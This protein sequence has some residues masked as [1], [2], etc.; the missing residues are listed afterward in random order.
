M[1]CIIFVLLFLSPAARSQLDV[2]L[3]YGTT[4]ALVYGQLACF[5][6]GSGGSLGRGGDTQNAGDAP[7][8]MAALAPIRFPSPTLVPERVAVAM[9]PVLARTCVLFYPPFSRALCFGNNMYGEC[10]DG[11]TSE[12]SIGE[13]LSPF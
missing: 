1:L 5:G 4:C 2:A 7:G 12:P 10:G 11:S 13:P 8:E 6:R 9:D 3:G